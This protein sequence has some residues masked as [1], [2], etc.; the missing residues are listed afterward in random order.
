M[1]QWQCPWLDLWDS[2]ICSLSDTEDMSIASITSSGY[3]Q[4]WLLE[5]GYW[6]IEDLSTTSLL[7]KSSR[8][9]TVG[10]PIQ[11][12]QIL[13]DN[14]FLTLEWQFPVA[15][16]IAFRIITNISSSIKCS[17]K[18]ILDNSGMLFHM[19]AINNLFTVL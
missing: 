16:Y 19:V 14:I 1:S 12:L 7:L 10:E 5:Y 17:N 4:V 6:H 11:W 2:K 9:A 3:Y 15:F 18:L 13:G 8:L